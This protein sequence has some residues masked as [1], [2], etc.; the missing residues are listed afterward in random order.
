[1]QLLIKRDKSVG[2]KSDNTYKEYVNYYLNP[3]EM[4][5]YKATVDE[6][7]NMMV[8]LLGSPQFFP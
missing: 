4:G 5:P 7:K 8:K 2:L 1:M 3:K 6:F